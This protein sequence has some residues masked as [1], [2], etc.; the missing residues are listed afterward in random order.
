M[1][2]ILLLFLLAPLASFA[3]QDFTI[4]GKIKIQNT[5]AK[6]M[7]YY[8]VNGKT[9]IDSTEMKDGVFTFKGQIA[10]PVAGFLKFKKEG[11]KPKPG[12]R[13]KTDMLSFAVEPGIISV[14]SP[15]DS[16]QSAVV[17]GT[18]VADGM[19]KHLAAQKAI[20][21]KVKVFME[22]YNA[23]TQEQK[24]D[25]VFV[26]PFQKGMEGF[27]AE[28]D[29]VP[30]DF[31]RSN[32]NSFASLILFKQLVFKAADPTASERLFNGLS[33]RLKESEMGKPLQQQ[34]KAAK[35]FAIGQQAP[36]FTQNDVDGKPV[37]LSDFK[38]K[39][40]LLDFWASWCGPCRT[41]NPW[42]KHM[43]ERYKDKNFTVLGVSLDNPGQKAAWLKA[44]ADDG[45]TWTNVSDLK[46]GQNEVA[47]QY[48]VQAIPASFLIGPDG[49]IIAKNLRGND[50]TKK[51]VELL[52]EIK[53][54]K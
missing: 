49:K 5:P 30:M 13:S 16:L 18:E 36:E 32:P 46:G 17:S 21:A 54:E 51:L 15:N 27:Q 48:L 45:L 10:E 44:I 20:L 38:G 11:P 33:A 41:E 4:N 12:M 7:L 42:V 52:G 22:P 28:L 26:R 6:V 53:A 2:K 40:V 37:R 23:A 43:Y 50:L 29:N 34:I 35:V 19:A 1:K 9:T 31:I 24:K 47:Q 14:V 8:T 3:Q 25:E 39:Y